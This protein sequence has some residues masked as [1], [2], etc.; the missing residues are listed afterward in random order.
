MK[1]NHSEN[2][3]FLEQTVKTEIPLALL[4]NARLQESREEERIVL[5][6]PRVPELIGARKKAPPVL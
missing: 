1:S 2:T 4:A 3:R 6:G 5:A